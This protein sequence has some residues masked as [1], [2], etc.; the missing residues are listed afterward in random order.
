MTS[1]PAAG[2]AGAEAPTQAEMEEGDVLE[3][4]LKM[5]FER[6]V[7]RT[8]WPFASPAWSGVVLLSKLDWKWAIRLSEWR[9]R[10]GQYRTD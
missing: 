3:S 10:P 1:S 9:V 6:C 4:V 5:T 2:C 7:S 8:N